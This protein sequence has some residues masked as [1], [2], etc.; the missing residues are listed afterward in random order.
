MCL[1]AYQIKSKYIEYSTITYIKINTN[2]R[3]RE[4][5]IKVKK[6][7]SRNLHQQGFYTNILNNPNHWSFT[8][9]KR[10]FIKSGRKWQCRWNHNVVDNVVEILWQC[11]W[12]DNVV[13]NVVEILWQCR[14]NIVKNQ[15]KWRKL[16][17]YCVCAATQRIKIRKWSLQP[18]H[19][20]TVRLLS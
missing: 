5:D 16:Q 20:T 4:G 15:R 8:N 9:R 17:K 13:D 6:K 3:N 10:W 11:R 2:K 7:N 18:A 14:W 12:N 1:I 19:I